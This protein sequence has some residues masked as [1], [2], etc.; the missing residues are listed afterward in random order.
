[1]K[2]IFKYLLAVALPALMLTGCIDETEPESS[3]ATSEQ[4]G[5]SSTALEASL[6]G[7]PSTMVQGYLIYGEQENETDMAYPQFMIA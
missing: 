5:S 2:K 4:I 3:Y 6:N 7:I 1:M